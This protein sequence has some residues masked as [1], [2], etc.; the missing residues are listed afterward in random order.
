MTP[1]AALKVER[2]AKPTSSPVTGAHDELTGRKI[3]GDI[4]QDGMRPTGQYMR[5]VFTNIKPNSCLWYGRGSAS[6]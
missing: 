4:V 3:D 2:S 1:N 5:W 6:R